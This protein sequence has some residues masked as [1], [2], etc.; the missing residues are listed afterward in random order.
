MDRSCKSLSYNLHVHGIYSLLVAILFEVIGCEFKLY[1]N[2]PTTGA[3]KSSVNLFS[4][5]AYILFSC[6]HVCRQLLLNK[7]D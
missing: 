1:A 5:C 7:Y 4:E 3:V 6:Q 2:A